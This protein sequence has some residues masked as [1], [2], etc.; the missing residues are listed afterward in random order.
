MQ[1]GGNQAAGDG[2]QG[3]LD[4]DRTV[5]LDRVATTLIGAVAAVGGV[6]AVLGANDERIVVL[7]DDD[8]AKQLLV[9]AA[10]AAVAS[11]A[12]SLW[13]LMV[14]RPG[15]EVVLLALGAGAY[16]AGLACAVF[17]AAGAA[18]YAAHPSISSVALE[19]GG[20]SVL[21]F[22]VRADSVDEQQSVRVEVVE[23][24]DGA[25]VFSADMRPDARGA[26]EQ[27][28]TIPVPGDV[29][30]LQVRAWRGDQDADLDT[31]DPCDSGRANIVCATIAAG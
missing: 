1:R 5:G 3:T 24:G 19:D 26:V 27:T 17:A 8:D 9:Y 16:I 25:V 29:T 28:V 10:L 31:A 6:L 14:R 23:G 2:D 22:T 7:L 4:D 20:P 30:E 13:A 15:G 12:L 21:R 18:D 11:V